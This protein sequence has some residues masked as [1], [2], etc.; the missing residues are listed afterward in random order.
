MSIQLFANLF[1]QVKFD[2]SPEVTA[3]TEAVLAERRK[4]S[5]DK[6][7]PSI[8]RLR[9]VYVSNH[10]VRRLPHPETHG[11]VCS[12]CYGAA[13]RRKAGEVRR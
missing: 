3:T 7:G 10:L 1:G 8:P 11:E 2:S 5:A 4:L 6:T 9:E 13:T 12:G